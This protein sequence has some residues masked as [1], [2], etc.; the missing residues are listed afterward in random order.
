MK[1]LHEGRDLLGRG[2]NIGTILDQTLSSHSRIQTLC[3]GGLVHVD[4]DAVPGS[5]LLDREQ[6]LCL[7]SMVHGMGST[8]VSINIFDVH[9]VPMF[10]MS[11]GVKRHEQL[12][13]KKRKKN[14]P[15]SY[16]PFLVQLE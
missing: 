16:C 2:E 4:V 7:L 5:D 15:G 11:V 14:P 13:Q 6:M 10:A 9:P 12:Q 1:E 8:I 3:V